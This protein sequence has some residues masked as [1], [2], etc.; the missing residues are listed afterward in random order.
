MVIARN[1]EASAAAV[2][3]FERRG[4]QTVSVTAQNDLCSLRL[5]EQSFHPLEWAR[6]FGW[7][8]ACVTERMHGAIFSLLNNIPFVAIEMNK[9]IGDRF[10]KTRSLL[11]RF[12][13]EDIL[14][15]FN[16]R[17][18]IKLQRTFKRAVD[19]PWDWDRINL[20]IEEASDQQ[21]EFLKG[22]MDG[23]GNSYQNT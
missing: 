6:L 10:T 7:F 8:D 21:V 2:E 5:H 9:A 16:E 23:V 14:L 15:D 19:M 4:W 20:Q 11:S 18:P 22:S 13:L 3:N 12:D 17:E 1:G